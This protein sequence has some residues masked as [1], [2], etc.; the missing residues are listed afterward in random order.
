MRL[1]AFTDVGLRILI[2]LAAADG[3][4]RHSTRAIADEMSVSYA[5]AA[6]ACARLAAFGWL[7]AGRGRGGGLFLTESGRVAGLGDVVHALEGDVES[8]LVDCAGLNC[9]LQSGCRLRTALAQA[10]GA[11]YQSLNTV[12]VAD[13]AQP[14]TRAL[15]IALTTR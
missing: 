3:S 14:P 10:E 12:A 1:T 11:F 6:K 5:H 8:E 2:R 13:L 7:D 15:V 9:P 4:E